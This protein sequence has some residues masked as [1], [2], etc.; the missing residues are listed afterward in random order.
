MVT[1]IRP[2]GFAGKPLFAASVISV[3]DLPPSEERN[4][5]L[6]DFAAGDS[7]PERNVQP[8]RRKS[9]RPAKITFGSCGSMLIDAQPVDRLPPLSTR[10]QVLPPSL[11]R[12]RP[13]SA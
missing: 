6:P 1:A 11:V 9:H 2:K 3:Q 7:P 8:L 12:Y 5:P 10:F 13:R 4:R